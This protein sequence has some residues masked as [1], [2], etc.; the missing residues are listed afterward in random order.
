M[1]NQYGP[2]ISQV[3]ESQADPRAPR[4]IFTPGFKFICL[5]A[6]L[7]L[8]AIC[9]LIL[10]PWLVTTRSYGTIPVALHAVAKAD[11]S[12]DTNQETIQP[13]DS[14]IILA[15]ILD[16][17]PDILSIPLRLTQIANEMQT[18]MSEPSPTTGPTISP[19]PTG[20]TLNT[21][22]P[23]PN[24]SPTLALTLTPNPTHEL[25]NPTFTSTLPP[26]EP[27]LTPAQEDICSHVRLAGFLSDTNRVYWKLINDGTVDVLITALSFNWPIQNSAFK[28]IEIS[29]RG[30]WHEEDET[31]PTEITTKWSGK[32][33][34]RSIPANNEKELEFRFEAT[35]AGSGYQINITLN[36]TCQISD[37]R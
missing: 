12:Q 5:T 34:H 20:S 21:Q 24:I 23:E 22:T 26:T 29:G 28:K 16:Q 1:S 6:I 10:A 4:L 19:A 30:V 14:S 33:D 18:P 37:N 17:D 36:S 3:D 31:P 27:P 8:T 7:V 32:I 15:A 11:Y 13:I 35:A 9:F 25:Q 2:G